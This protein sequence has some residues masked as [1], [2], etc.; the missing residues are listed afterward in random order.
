MLHEK[1]CASFYVRAN[2]KLGPMSRRSTSTAKRDGDAFPTRAKL[3][4]PPEGLGKRLDEMHAWLREN[5]SGGGHAGHV[6]RT[7]GGTAWP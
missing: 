7:V 4:V 5:L 1:H 3:A 6:A 2:A